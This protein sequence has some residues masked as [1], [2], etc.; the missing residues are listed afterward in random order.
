MSDETEWREMQYHQW[1]V[2]SAPMGASTSRM[3]VNGGWLYREIQWGN[4]WGDKW[5][6]CSVAITFVPVDIT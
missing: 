2:V 3:K 4:Q 1:Q 6:P 5:G